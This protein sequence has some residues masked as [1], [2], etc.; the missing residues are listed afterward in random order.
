MATKNNEIYE[1]PTTEVVEV[2]YEGVICTS[3]VVTATMNN[4]WQEEDI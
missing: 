2:K 4:T 3:G 1:V